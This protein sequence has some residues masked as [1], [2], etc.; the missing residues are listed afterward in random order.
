MRVPEKVIDANGH[1]NNVAFVQWMQEAATRHADTN[2]GTEAT[3]NCQATWV[4]RSHTIEYLGPAYRDDHLTVLTWVANF[5]KVRSLR[6]Y[7]FLRTKDRRLLVRGE[8]DW[9]LVDRRTGRPR[10]IPE[11]VRGV[12]PVVPPEQEP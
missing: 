4:V 7:R 9:V 11:S 6:R 2:G 3:R 12:F 5:R 10:S 8:T 1:V